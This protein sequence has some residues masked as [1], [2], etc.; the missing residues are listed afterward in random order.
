MLRRGVNY[1]MSLFSKRKKLIISGCSY[2]D[3]YARKQKMEEFPIW[4]ELLA[5]QLD[6]DLINL[7]RC[8]YGNGAIYHTLIEE[9]LNRKDIGLVVAMWSEVQRVSFF[10]NKKPV[11]LK[12][13]GVHI[14][15]PWDCFHPERIVLDAEW[16]DKFFIPPT[17][18]TKKSGLKYDI[19]VA[20]RNKFLDDIKG[21]VKESI[22]YMY[23][24][25]TICESN[26]IPHLQIQGCQPL[27]GKAEPL[28]G[29]QYK[30]LCNFIIESP[31]IDKINKTFIGWPIDPRIGGY[32]IDSKLE[33]KHR[34]S[35]EDTHPNKEG[36]K[37][38]SEIL[39]EFHKS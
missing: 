6:M 3:N 17:K 12:N 20:L 14:S 37:L 36:H 13:G 39:Y 21:G 38:I 16:H 9:I 24:F 23:A 35:P 11:P 33:D 22:G 26:N 2:T 4:G 5:E 10:T 28:Q 31:Y 15:D 7:S 1:I 32:S 18:N 30:E 34:F 27:M 8:G 29:I 19:S 25:Q